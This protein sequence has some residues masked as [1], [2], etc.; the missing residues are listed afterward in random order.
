MSEFVYPYGAD[1]NPAYSEFKQLEDVLLEEYN[2]NVS[3]KPHLQPIYQLRYNEAWDLLYKKYSDFLIPMPVDQYMNEFCLAI[4]EYFMVGIPLK[5]VD[6]KDSF[7]IFEDCS[8]ISTSMRF[9]HEKCAIPS[10]E[11]DQENKETTL[12]MYSE[13]S[14]QLAV[15][16]TKD[17][18]QKQLTKCEMLTDKYTKSHLMAVEKSTSMQSNSQSRAQTHNVVVANYE[19]K[20]AL[21]NAIEIINLFPDYISGIHSTKN[22]VVHSQCLI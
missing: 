16:Y 18:L 21:K 19:K 4:G 3:E 20:L 12:D 14:K 1:R 8:K 7:L 22:K 10:N 6:A 5:L 17:E 15:S 11:G 13:W 2:R 9:T